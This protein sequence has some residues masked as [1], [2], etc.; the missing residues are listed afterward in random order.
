MSTEQ[1]PQLTVKCRHDHRFQTRARRGAVISC[2]VCRRDDRTRVAVYIGPRA[3]VD[4]MPATGP[5]APVEQHDEHERATADDLH[6]EVTRLRGLVDDLT[7][8]VEAA[9]RALD[10]HE[11][12]PAGDSDDYRRAI[13]A[14]WLHQLQHA[15]SAAGVVLAGGGIT[16][17]DAA[18]VL[19]VTDGCARSRLSEAAKLGMIEQSRAGRVNVYVFTEAQTH[20][21]HLVGMP[22]ADTGE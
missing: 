8:Q 5:A 16:V 15:F 18:D 19:G 9:T 12:G 13:L 17:H 21:Y 2:P 7:R 14:R 11:H 3:I 22:P 1:N 6:A 20:L 10:M 4:D